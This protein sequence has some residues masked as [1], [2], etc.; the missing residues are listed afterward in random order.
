MFRFLIIEIVGRISKA[1]ICGAGGAQR[2]VSVIIGLERLARS[3]RRT[4]A[5][6]RLK[7][8]SYH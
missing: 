6:A 7:P 8:T 5:H 4:G 2:P 3:A 1:A